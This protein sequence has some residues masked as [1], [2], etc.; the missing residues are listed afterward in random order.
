MWTRAF[1]CN[2]IMK[3]RER[4]WNNS[5]EIIVESLLIVRH[6][7]NNQ[8]P[9]VGKMHLALTALLSI[10][11][12]MW[13]SPAR[14]G[15]CQCQQHRYHHQILLSISTK[16]AAKQVPL[17]LKLQPPSA[18]GPSTS[19]MHTKDWKRE[20]AHLPILLREDYES[21]QHLVDVP[22]LCLCL[23]CAY[24]AWRCQTVIMTP[25]L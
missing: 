19:W 8:N 10:F 25:Q 9:S 16:D 23:C 11:G 15:D 12:A 20:T 22:H 13:A 2:L 24:V 4:L 3:L 18:T 7:K 1:E 21:S 6:I 5:R 14:K 17:L